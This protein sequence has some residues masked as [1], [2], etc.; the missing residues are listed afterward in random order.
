[1]II[2][3]DKSQ[4]LQGT[5]TSFQS[6]SYRPKTQER[7]MFQFKGCTI[8]KAEH[9][10][11]DAFELWSWRRFLRVP[12]TA[13]RSNQ[14]I[15][16]ELNP[17]YSLEGLI[18]R[19]KLQYFGHLMRKA[20]IRKDPDAG[21][22]WRQ[23]EKGM[24]EDEMVGW[25]H[26]LNGHELEQAL[27]VGKGQGSLA[28][29]CPWGRKELDMTEWLNNNS[30]KVVWQEEFSLTENKFNLSVLF[31]PSTDWV[32]PTSLFTLGRV[33]WFIHSTDSSVNLIQKTPTETSRINV[34]VFI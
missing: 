18:L 25:H 31:S 11:I 21:K 5:L 1:M 3:A 16:K 13:R 14:W 34:W 32:R 10:R 27:G 8:K 7:L 12:L 26:Q 2:K 33:I 28:C 20:D 23:E 24:T 19:L 4:D 9:Q 22:D 30:S 17:E 6:E 15:L 29:Y